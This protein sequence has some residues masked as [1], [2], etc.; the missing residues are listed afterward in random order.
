VT[1]AG[2][3]YDGEIILNKMFYHLNE[4]A[5]Q[6]HA[7]IARGDL[8]AAQAEFERVWNCIPE[9]KHEHEAI[10]VFVQA[11]LRVLATS[12]HPTYALPWIDRCKQ[13]R[14]S[15]IDAEP[16]F[17]IGVTY[18]E[19]NDKDLAFEHFKRALTMSE[20]RAFSDEDPKYLNFLNT[21]SRGE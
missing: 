16:D 13:M 18:Y 9:P 15:E 12:G 7:A 3:T 1:L 11:A 4:I 19:L 5:D 10:N 14:A 6:V 20:G 2:R 8:G 21:Y 17:L